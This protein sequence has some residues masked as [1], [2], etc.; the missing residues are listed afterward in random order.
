MTGQRILVT[1]TGSVP[2]SPELTRLLQTAAAGDAGHAAL[3][4]YLAAATGAA[5]TW[6]RRNGVDVVSDGEVDRL[7]FMDARRLGFDGPPMPFQIAD[8]AAAGDEHWAAG[9]FTGSAAVA[10]PSNTREITYDPG[11]AAARIARFRAVLDGLDGDP[12]AGA[13]LT[14][15][16]PGAVTL[17]G[18]SYY[19]DA[20]DFLAAAAA[21]LQHEYRAITAAGLTLQVDAPDLALPYHVHYQG[22]SVEEFRVRA[23]LHADAINR[24]LAGIDPQQIRLHVC[25]GNYP[26][27]HHRD[28]PLAAIIDILHSVH[29]GTLV[30]AGASPPHRADWRMFAASKLPAGKTLAAGVIDTATPGIE[31]PVAVADAIV[32]VAGAVGPDRVMATT[33][34]GFA[35]FPGTPAL[36]ARLAELK[37]Q[38]LRA[39]ADMATRRLWRHTRTAAAA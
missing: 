38:A 11:P 4:R 25:W 20:G 27:P 3:E 19:R 28:I 18:S 21:A 34:C 1:I 32:Q 15:P 30:L 14:A 12:P 33:D 13:F 6:Q 8:L 26:G 36:P 10:L 16:S 29:T 23:Q 37:V 39:G 7:S 17:A 35:A 24:A 2:R 31:A 9:Y 22:M 5:V